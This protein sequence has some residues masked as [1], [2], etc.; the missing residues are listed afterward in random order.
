MAFQTHV[1]QIPSHSVRR[2]P[3]RRRGRI[4][5]LNRRGPSRRRR[6]GGLTQYELVDLEA[7]CPANTKPCG[8]MS[9][10]NVFVCFD[11]VN[12][13]QINL[14]VI[15][16]KTKSPYK[17]Y[18]PLLFEDGFFWI[19]AN[20]M[21]RIISWAATSD[22]ADKKICMQPVKRINGFE[23]SEKEGDVLDDYVKGVW[24]KDDDEIMVSIDSQN[25]ESL[26]K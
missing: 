23:N 16:E 24:T 15:N 4:S 12:P 18:V 6:L 5:W 21:F 25:K 22:L 10:A 26:L 11:Q 1:R 13:C 19:I 7:T 3:D 8:R 17:M 2:L 20:K 9:K 14:I